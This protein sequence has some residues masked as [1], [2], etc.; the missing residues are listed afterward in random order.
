MTVTQGVQ[1][2]FFPG[3]MLKYQWSFISNFSWF[4][5]TL[6]T[7]ASVCD[8]IGRYIAGWKDFVPKRYFFA[9]AL[10]RGVFF[11]VLFMLTYEEVYVTV[12]G[13]DWFIISALGIFASTAGYWT[14][15]GMKHGC[16]EETKDQ[17]L[18]GTIMGFHLTLGIS[19]GSTVA[20]ACLS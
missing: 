2:A 12:F 6:V 15:V 9:S 10:V 16:D 19:I 11:V 14:T 20:I 4:V 5:I 17:G 1:M 7:Y 3:V 8:T 18:A 13:S